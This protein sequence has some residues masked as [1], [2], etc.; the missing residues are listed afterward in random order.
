M[1]KHPITPLKNKTTVAIAEK[2]KTIS[3]PT[4]AVV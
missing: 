3:A 1:D 4:P 2:N